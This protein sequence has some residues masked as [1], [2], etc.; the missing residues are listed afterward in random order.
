MATKD[1]VVKLRE[2]TGA[3]VMDCKRALEDAQGDFD[4]A[5][6]IIQEKG[7]AK[8]E[9]REGRETGAGRIEAYIHNNRVGV[10]I[11]LRSETDFVAK[12]EPFVKLAHDLALQLVAMPAE[13]VEEFLSQPF[14]RN[15]SRVVK[16]LITDVIAQVGENIQ[17]KGFARREI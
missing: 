6:I 16:D 17:L 15:E 3:G 11:E 2:V 10:L 7:L 5:R 8:A 12:S 14:I 13:T 9:K 1:D 4:K